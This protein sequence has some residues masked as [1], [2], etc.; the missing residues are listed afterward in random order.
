M[1]VLHVLLLLDV[2]LLLLLEELLQQLLHAVR[3]LL[4]GFD[5]HVVAGDD[6]VLVLAHVVVEVV[7]SLFCVAV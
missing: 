7:L 3:G 2:F 5:G 4:V 1:C 6:D